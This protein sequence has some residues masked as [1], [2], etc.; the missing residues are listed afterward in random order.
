[1]Q[2]V[3]ELK[4]FDWFK[5]DTGPTWYIVLSVKLVSSTVTYLFFGH[6]VYE[7]KTQF[8]SHLY[9][10]P[11]DKITIMPRIISRHW[12]KSDSQTAVL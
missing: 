1:M 6:P 8:E 7:V 4:R 5:I 9:L 3:E 10:E 12:F 2:T 11:T